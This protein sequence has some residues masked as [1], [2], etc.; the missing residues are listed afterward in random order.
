[1]SSFS[2]RISII[3][4]DESFSSATDVLSSPGFT[5]VNA[6]SGPVAPVRI[7][8]ADTNSI[9][10]ILG[11]PNSTY[12]EIQDVLDYNSEFPLFV[13]APYDATT[14]SVPV[15]YVTPA[16]VFPRADSVSLGGILLEQINS[17]GLTVDGITEFSTAQTVLVPLGNEAT[18]FGDTGVGSQTIQDTAQP[19]TYNTS[20]PSP[21]LEFNFGFD[22]SPAAGELSDTDATPIHPLYDDGEGTDL[23]LGRVMTAP[24]GSFVG[25]LV[26]DIPGEALIDLQLFSVAGPAI[27]VRTPSGTTLANIAAS[28]AVTSLAIDG[29]ASLTGD[30]ALYQKYFTETALSTTWASSS[31]RSTVRV[32]WKAQLDEDAIFATVYPK[33]VSGR[34]TTL[35]FTRQVYGNQLTF[36]GTQQVT[37]NRSSQRFLSGSLVEGARDGFGNSLSFEDAAET[38]NL[39]NITVIKAFDTDTVFTRTGTNT[40][41]NITL[42]SVRLSRG[43]RSQP[44]TLAD[45]WTQATDPD[46]DVVE[47][48]FAPKAFTPGQ[49]VVFTAVANTHRLAR[50]IFPQPIQPADVIDGQVDELSF[51]SQFFVT[52][53]QFIRTSSYTQE[54][55][56]TSLI[57]AYSRMISRIIVNRFGGVAPMFLNNGGNPPLGGQLGVRVQRALFKY[58]AEQLG[59]LDGANYNPIV[60]DPNYGVLVTSQKTAKGGET[61]D[62][63]YIGHASAFLFFQRQIRDQVMI[64]QLGKA[65]NPFFRNLRASQVNAL[66]A[67]RIE[68]LNRIWASVVVDTQSV[69]DADTLAQRKFKIGV[70]VRV[71]IFSEGVELI[72]TNEGQQ[73]ITETA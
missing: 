40:G 32:Y 44:A 23:A 36:T 26:L 13:S 31:F 62:F 14:S 12:P 10:E 51:G 17:D 35:S 73:V 52:T 53:G 59:I 45:G 21:T 58:S 30:T 63:S 38:Q 16:G 2:N 9:E 5:V 1:M 49:E 70:R 39:L 27:E 29:S 48:F 67:P 61:S 56:T 46:Y 19:L 22:I 37:P 15:A 3:N 42:P 50:F 11:Y 68:G 20:G 54:K 6:E 72:L 34:A 71:D 55:I 28:G 33:Y 57:G 66:A 18:L 24:V 7:S 69:N 41:P 65:N 8:A 47:V 25:V 4:R 43:V 60:N 64:P